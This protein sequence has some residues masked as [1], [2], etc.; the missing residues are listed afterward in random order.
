MNISE[1]NLFW[2]EGI[3]H[4]KQY[5][6][7]SKDRLCDALV[8]G[9]GIGGALT[10]YMQAKQG[11]NVIVV[12]K[13]ILGYGA[14]LTT[15]GTLLRRIDLTDSKQLKYLDEKTIDKCNKLCTEAVDNI[16]KIID[17]ISED[18]DCKKYIDKLELKEMDLM[19]YSEKITGKISMYKLFEKLGRKDKRIEY[20]EQDPV[21]NLR[22]GIVVPNGGVVL[23]P[24]VLTQLIFMYLSK[25]QNVE[26]YENT[27]ID[28]IHIKDEKVE[29]I[30]N[31]RIKI[32]SKCVILTTGI[33]TL[34]Y[35]EN[36]DLSINKIF[37]IVTE[38]VDNLEVNDINIIAKDMA[39]SNSL[40]TFTKDKRIIFSGEHCKDNEKM[41]DEKYFKNFSNGR[42]K[43]LYY[44][45]NKLLGF[46]KLPKITNC[47]YGVY[48]DTKDTLPIID[49]IDSMP[50]VYCN[51]GTGRNG[52]VYSMVGANM[53]KDIS[54]KYHI[55]DMYMFREN[56]YV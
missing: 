5:P 38:S 32:N 4:L 24:Y 22:T 20:L 41:L 13:N 26:I 34:K 36:D 27:C 29:C 9:G 40:V 1:G 11:N 8:I 51:L 35:M 23:N 48:I 6:Y 39:S 31:N 17:E 55:K 21:I 49:E 53:L 44:S 54:K 37:T 28:K 52:I 15:D 10:A 2:N 30:T 46:N 33:H 7:I 45:L 47:F 14:T 56:R 19:G 50:N 43:K 12:D 18:E 42:Y 25:K 3:T 16:L